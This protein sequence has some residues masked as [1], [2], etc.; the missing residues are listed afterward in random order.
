MQVDSLFSLVTE[1]TNLDK[2]KLMTLFWKVMDP[3]TKNT[4]REIVN[5]QGNVCNIDWP[6]KS[7]EVCKFTN[8][9]I[10]YFQHFILPAM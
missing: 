9:D 4:D 3:Y 7:N 5:N 8:G 2:Y 10:F 6:I 1:N